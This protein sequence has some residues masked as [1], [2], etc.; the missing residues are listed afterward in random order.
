MISQTAA[1]WYSRKL[2]Q[3]HGSGQSKEK[4]I[5][6]RKFENELKHVQDELNE[7]VSKLKLDFSKKISKNLARVCERQ[8]SD[9]A[10]PDQVLVSIDSFRSFYGFMGYVSNGLKLHLQFNTTKFDQVHKQYLDWYVRSFQSA[11]QT[12]LQKVLDDESW[13]QVRV[14]ALDQ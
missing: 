3:T 1:Q 12:Q 4:M 13:A 6:E 11:K 7:V 9:F 14:T 8:K 5:L 2:T 10:K